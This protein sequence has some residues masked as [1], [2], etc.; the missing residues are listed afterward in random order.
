MS[1]CWT[2]TPRS[3]PSPRYSRR[4]NSSTSLNVLLP[5]KKWLTCTF[6]AFL[7]RAFDQV[8]IGT[9]SQ[10]NINLIGSHCTLSI[11]DGPGGFGH[12]PKLHHFLSS[13]AV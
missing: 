12:V 8:R 6:A 10:T 13:D 5:S 7:T 1:L 3:P 4:S 11:S 2:V 9:I